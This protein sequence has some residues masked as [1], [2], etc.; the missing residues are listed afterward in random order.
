MINYK[1][2]A[3]LRLSKEEFKSEKEL[4][5]IKNQRQIINDY[6]KEHKY[7]DLIDYYIDDGYSGMNFNRP[8]FSRLL[9]DLKDKKINTI[10]VKDL[11]RIRRNYDK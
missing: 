10:I 3:Y 1:V 5:S 9:Q 11:S 7:L 6:I 4:N 2:G 8:E